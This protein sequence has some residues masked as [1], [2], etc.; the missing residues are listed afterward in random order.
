MYKTLIILICFVGFASAQDS[1]KIQNSDISVYEENDSVRIIRL[2]HE[3]QIGIL[4]SF[5]QGRYSF[6]EIGLAFLN[7]TTVGHHPLSS[8]YF[9]SNEFRIG[10]KF[11]MGPK[12]GF[13]FSGGVAFGLN[14]IYYT[15]FD[16]GALVFRPEIGGGILGFKIVYGYNWNLTNKNFRGINNHFAGITYSFPIRKTTKIKEVKINSNKN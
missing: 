7:H 4:T 13:W 15:D 10:D 5:Y 12:I 2:Q 6:G 3:R 8:A 16:D 1:L 14:A 9:I 11:I